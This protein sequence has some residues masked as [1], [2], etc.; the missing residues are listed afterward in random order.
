MH[1]DCNV[2]VWR[3]CERFK[4]HLHLV[5]RNIFAATLGYWLFALL[6]VVGAVVAGFPINYIAKNWD[7]FTAFMGINF[8]SI[9]TFVIV[10]AGKDINATFV[11]K[12][13]PKKISKPFILFFV[14]VWISSLLGKVLR[15]ECYDSDVA[16][17]LSTKLCNY[18]DYIS[19]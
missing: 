7:W 4:V 13:G 12:G 9:L 10:V 18:V 16:N 5:F 6:F 1:F 3:C 15:C 11:Q 14:S 8:M 19:T 2:L 17:I